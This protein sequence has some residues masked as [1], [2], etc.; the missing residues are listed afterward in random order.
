MIVSCVLLVAGVLAV[1]L[2][3]FLLPFGYLFGVFPGTCEVSFAFVFFVGGV[4]TFAE[5]DAGAFKL[6]RF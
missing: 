3:V 1:E 5:V 2:L 6:E 4:L